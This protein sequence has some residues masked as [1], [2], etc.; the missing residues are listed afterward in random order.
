MMQRILFLFLTIGVLAACSED[1]NHVFDVMMPKGN[2]RFEPV[3]GGAVMFYNLPAEENV[4]G[5][6][7]RYRDCRGVETLKVGSYVGDS[8]VIDGF[9]EATKNVPARVSLVDCNNNESRSLDVTFDTEESSTYAFFHGVEVLPDWE[10]FQVRYGNSRQAS[11]MIHVMYAGTNP[12]TQQPDTILLKSFPLTLNGDT[13][14]FVLQQQREKNTVIIR[15]EDFRG[16]R[17]GQRVWENVDAYFTEKLDLTEDNFIDK[18]RCSVENENEKVGVEYLF[19]GD[20]K[21]EKRLIAGRTPWFYCFM[22]GPLIHEKSLIFDM[23]TERVPAR[24]RLY[25]PLKSVVGWPLVSTLY[26]SSYTWFKGVFDDKLPCAVTVYGGNDVNGENWVK[27]GSYAQDA[28]TAPENRWSTAC[29]R[30]SGDEIQEE[31]DMSEADPAYLE[32]Q[33]PC[34]QGMEKY[35]Y[36]KLVIDELFKYVLS[37]GLV[38]DY[39]PNEYVALSEFEIYVKKD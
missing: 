35:R 10:G 2:I 38:V 4:F 30:W 33:F 25:G 14:R 31:K 20:T 6:R 19:D 1:T 22:A 13:L 8:L 9:N 21:G 26:T 16:Y 34:T 32:V 39:N 5:I 23:K 15:T 37:S 28:G 3:P 12:L 27:I 7:L 36:I 17:V 18:E 11:G 24:V 29:G